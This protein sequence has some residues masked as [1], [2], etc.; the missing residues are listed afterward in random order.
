MLEGGT[1][2][3]GRGAGGLRRKAG[4]HPKSPL[5]GTEANSNNSKP[6]DTGFLP[7]SRV[8]CTHWGHCGKMESVPLKSPLWGFRS[9]HLKA[10]E[11]LRSW[12][13][14]SEPWSRGKDLSC[15]PPSSGEPK[16]KTV[17]RTGTQALREGQVP[18]AWGFLFIPK[19]KGTETEKPFQMGPRQSTIKAKHK[20]N[21][22][23]KLHSWHAPLGVVKHGYKI[24]G[25]GG[26]D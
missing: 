20:T 4:K 21:T 5:R 22:K 18:H 13:T 7:D 25:D 17:T 11:P 9:V 8:A 12:S 3:A 19:V 24:G 16:A 14:H 15:W 6:A 10:S 2:E 26:E 1:P 23:Q